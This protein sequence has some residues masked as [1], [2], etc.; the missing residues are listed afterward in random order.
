MVQLLRLRPQV[1]N[2]RALQDGAVAASL[3]QL[4]TLSLLDFS[5]NERTLGVPGEHA[6]SLARAL[7][8]LPALRNL[9]IDGLGHTLQ[10]SA[11]LGGALAQ[12]TGI[13]ALSARHALLGCELSNAIRCMRG[14]GASNLLLLCV[15]NNCA[16]LAVDTSA[17]C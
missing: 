4:S 10:A 16:A 12:C 13:R 15:E 8:Q 17:V 7:P 2:R 9:C 14:C 3:L 5:I 6:A 1:T 11:V